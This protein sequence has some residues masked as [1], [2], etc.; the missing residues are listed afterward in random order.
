MLKLFVI[1]RLG[2]DAE[3]KEINGNIVIDFPLVHVR[4]YRSKDVS[5]NTIITE[6]PT[7]LNCSYWIDAPKLLEFLKKG[8][9][10]YLE[11]VPDV[12]GYVKEGVVLGSLRLKVTTLELV[13]NNKVVPARENVAEDKKLDAEF[14][15]TNS[16]D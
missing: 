10:V 6:K 13:G 11:G 3:Q 12:S 1:G 7:W 2:K 14:S 5:G 4:K 8:T 16:N 15:P 9:Q